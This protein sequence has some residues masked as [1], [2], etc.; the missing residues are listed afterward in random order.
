MQHSKVINNLLETNK[1]CSDTTVLVNTFTAILKEFK[2]SYINSLF[3]KVK[4]R[5]FAGA[6]IFELLFVLRFYSFFLHRLEVNCQL[7][8]SLSFSSHLC[9]HPTFSLSLSL[10]LC[11][12]L[13]LLSLSSCLWRLTQRRRHR[14]RRMPTFA[15]KQ[16]LL[17]N[18]KCVRLALNRMKSV[19]IVQS[20]LLAILGINEFCTKLDC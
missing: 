18:P 7:L 1:Y 17:T 9:S 20:L 12:S 5:G 16:T 15:Y 3:S 4:N 14:R 8:F 11:F 13:S 2:L 19:P 10:S 6:K